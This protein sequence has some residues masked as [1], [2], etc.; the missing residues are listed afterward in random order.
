[1]KRISEVV[2][3][4]KIKPPLIYMMLKAA[5]LRAAALRAVMKRILQEGLIIELL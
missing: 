3:H 5:A 1:M 4:Q 2:E